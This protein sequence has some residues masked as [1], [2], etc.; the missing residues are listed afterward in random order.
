MKILKIQ[1][2]ASVEPE[3]IENKSIELPHLNRG[4]LIR[5][6]KKENDVKEMSTKFDD[7]SIPDKPMENISY[8]TL[9]TLKL[10]DDSYK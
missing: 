2:G 5:L 1:I 9:K 7:I 8:D 3:K 6:E 4:D 10:V